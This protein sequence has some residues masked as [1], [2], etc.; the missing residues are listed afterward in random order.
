MCRWRPFAAI[1]ARE[2]LRLD[3]MGWVIPPARFAAGVIAIAVAYF[4][5][6]VLLTIIADLRNWIRRFSGWQTARN[7][8]NCLS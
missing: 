7:R 8:V 3:T 5:R 2:L 1:I 6:H 4:T